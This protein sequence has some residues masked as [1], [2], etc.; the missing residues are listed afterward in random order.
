MLRTLVVRFSAHAASIA[1]AFL[2]WFGFAATA[3][4]MMSSLLIG[5]ARIDVVIERTSLHAP[6]KG[7]FL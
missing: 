6:A 2:S 5:N 4:E 3:G 1:I 7:I